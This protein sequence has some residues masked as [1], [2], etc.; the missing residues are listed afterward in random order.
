MEFI[1]KVL[2]SDVDA[3]MSDQS[4]IYAGEDW[5]N[6]IFS[7]LKE[8]KVLVSMLSP[9]S[10][11][12]PWINFE[13][14]AAWMGEVKVIPTCFW[15]LDVGKLPK[16][17]SNLQAVNLETHEGSFYLADSIAHHLKL[18]PPKKPFFEDDLSSY[19]SLG[20]AID[21]DENKK[22]FMPYQY[23]NFIVKLHSNIRAGERRFYETQG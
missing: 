11:Q 6:R 22:M 23:L 18:A 14:G 5:M 7:E 19:K 10:I 16:P 20:L 17:Y 4:T 8:S 2:G 1:H 15:G 12:R 21:E 9:V 13:A 3:F